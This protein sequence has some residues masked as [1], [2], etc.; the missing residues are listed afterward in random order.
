MRAA[1]AVLPELLPGSLP[2][3]LPELLPGHGGRLKPRL[4]ALRAAKSASADWGEARVW[5]V[6]RLL[7]VLP[8]LPEMLPEML[9]E[10]L[11]VHC[12]TLM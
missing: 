1:V 8:F 11:Q 5:R 7:R 12:R 2:E 4:G 6:G 3:L 10:F 9:P